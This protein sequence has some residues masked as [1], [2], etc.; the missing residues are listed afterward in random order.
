MSRKSL[1]SMIKAGEDVSQSFLAEL[2]YTIENTQEEYIPSKTIKPSSLF[3][4]RQSV[5]QIIGAEMDDEQKNEQ[6]IG[7]CELGSATHLFIQ[8]TILKSRNIEYLNVSDYI[9]ENNI[10]LEVTKESDFENGEPETKVYSKKFNISCLCDGI[11]KFKNKLFILEIKTISS[12]QFFK[13]DGVLD[14]HKQQAISYSTLFD[15][16]DVLF[17][18]ISRDFF[19]MKLF[20]YTPTNKERLDWQQNIEYI[21]SCVKNG[22]IPPIPKEKSGKFCNYCRYKNYCEVVS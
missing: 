15:I 18:Y 20:I 10:D 19:Q 8:N 22:E 12:G 13:L 11:V 1:I 17:L 21:L 6:S 5:F 4:P 2:S 16:S 7:I 9:K 3:C 14:K